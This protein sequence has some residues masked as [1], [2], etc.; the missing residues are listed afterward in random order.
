[1]N[2]KIGIYIEAVKVSSKT[3]ISRHIIGLVEALVKENS[4]NL[5]Y[6]YYQADP[7]EKEKLNWLRG[8]QNV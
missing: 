4:D 1:V 8:L 7:F 2:L 3:G 6:L 5:Y